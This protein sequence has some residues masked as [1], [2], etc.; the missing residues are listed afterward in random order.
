MT[1]RSG[2]TATELSQDNMNAM[3]MTIGD[4]MHNMGLTQEVYEFRL[5]VGLSAR[6]ELEQARIKEDAVLH[7]LNGKRA[8]IRQI[9]ERLRDI[10]ADTL[11]VKES[12]AMWR[13][14][15]NPGAVLAKLTE[16]LRNERIRLQNDPEY[17]KLE[18]NLKVLRAV[19]VRAQVNI[20]LT[21]HEDKSLKDGGKIRRW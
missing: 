3:G 1:E 19:I 21:P 16:R 20:G 11:T 10:D 6:R 7:L 15:F 12:R 9:K 14:G 17:L 2:N 13:K 5:D 18:N 4:F 8:G